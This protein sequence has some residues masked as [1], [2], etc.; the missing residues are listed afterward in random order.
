M[1][2]KG[3]FVLKGEVPSRPALDEYLVDRY[4][5]FVS[6]LLD[7]TDNRADGKVLH[8]PEVVRL[9]DDD[10][11]LV[12]AADKGTAHL[13]DT[14]N[15]VSAQYGFWLG[16]AFASGGSV[17]LRPQ[18]DGHHRPRGVGVRA[19]TTSATWARTSR[20]SPSPWP[21]SATCRATS[22]ATACSSRGRSSWWRPSTTGTSSSTPT[23]TPRRATASASALFALPRSSWR[24]YDPALLS[25]GGGVYDR[26]AKAIPLS[27]EARKLLD[28]EGDEPSGEEVI[29][30]ILTARVDL[31]YNGGIGTYVKAE[32]ARSTPT[33]ATAPTTACG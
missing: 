20:R 3:G 30:K 10:P 5:E 15:R 25:P 28:V 31:L 12:V 11:Y 7:V 1:G 16:D 27:P 9:D 19:S 8:P 13:S 29:R 32:S 33:S 23:P 26:S 21:G 24:D 22:S 17:G 4:R 18:E 2:S 14:A 6:G